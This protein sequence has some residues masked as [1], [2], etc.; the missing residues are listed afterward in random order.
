MPIP[1]TITIHDAIY[2]TPGVTIGRY[3][4]RIIATQT[5]RWKKP[6]LAFEYRAGPKQTWTPAQ[7]GLF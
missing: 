5:G 6:T 1:K 3:Q 7:A 2:K 4:W